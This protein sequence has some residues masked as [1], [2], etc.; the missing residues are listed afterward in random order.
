[1]IGSSGHRDRRGS[2]P[3]SFRESV[4][5]PLYGDGGCNNNT[6][7]GDGNYRCSSP[8]C[9]LVSGDIDAHLRLSVYI[10]CVF[11]FLR[12]VFRTFLDSVSFF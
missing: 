11:S 1:V 9:V 4:T 3:S 12:T 10:L 6:V 2:T 5:V 8:C 7:Q